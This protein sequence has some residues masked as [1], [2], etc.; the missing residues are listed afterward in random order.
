MENTIPYVTT[1]GVMVTDPVLERGSI[2]LQIATEDDLELLL[3]WRSHPEVYRYFREQEGP[4]K[5]ED[6]YRFWRAR[7]DR[8]DWIILFDDGVR[9]RKVGSVNITNISS[10]TPEVGILIG[11]ITLMGRGVGAQSV[12][13]VV[14]WLKTRGY[15]KVRARTSLEN[16]RSQRLFESLGF[17]TRGETDDETQMIYEKVL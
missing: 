3:A 6:H 9:K 16:D 11:E 2:Q 15:D 10:K 12:G 5:W 7:Q 13:L 8:I 14:E 4:L 1:E 17:E